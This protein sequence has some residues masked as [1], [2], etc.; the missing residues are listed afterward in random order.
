MLRVLLVNSSKNDA[1]ELAV[2]L[3]R[4]G[5]SVAACSGKHDAVNQLKWDRRGFDAVIVDLTANR[6]EDWSAFDEIRRIAWAIAHTTRIVCFST[7]NRGAQMRLK[8]ER[9]GGRFVYL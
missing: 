5:Y 8:V 6:P 2:A 3:E 7:V 1:E 4:H 9:K